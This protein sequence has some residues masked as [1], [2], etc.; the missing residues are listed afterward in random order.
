[1]EEFIP[2]YPSPDD[3]DIQ[4]IITAKKE[5]NEFDAGLCSNR[6][7]SS[8]GS[9]S[10][11]RPHQKLFERLCTITD[12]I[13]NIHETGTGKTC[14]FIGLTEHYKDTGAYEKVLI[15]EKNEDLIKEIKDQ[16]LHKCT[17]EGEYSIEKQEGDSDVKEK[18]RLR[19][20]LDDWYTFVT[21]QRFSTEIADMS[22]AL[23]AAKYS[24]MIIIFD[25]GHNIYSS[26]DDKTG[27]E[28]G[29]FD[30]VKYSNFWKFCHSVK[31]CKICVVTA[32]PMLNKHTEGLR[33]VNLLLPANRQ[34]PIK[35]R[36]PRYELAEL[37]PYLR[38][39]ISFFGAA[40]SEV[41][42]EYQGQVI[43]FSGIPMNMYLSKMGD[44]QTETYK[45]IIKTSIFSAE[46]TYSSFVL[47]IINGKETSQDDYIK[48][49]NGK[50]SW[51]NNPTFLEWEH[52]GEY[53]SF[54]EWIAEKDTNGIPTRDFT[55][56]RRLSG[57]MA[58]I[59]SIETTEPGCSFIYH[60]LVSK[61]GI[62]LLYMILTLFGFE[63]FEK[64]NPSTIF[65]GPKIRLNYPKKLRVAYISGDTDSN[66]AEVIKNLF[67][68]PENANGEYLKIIIG[69]RKVRDGVNLFNC[70]RMHLLYPLWNYSSM[71][72]AINRVLRADGHDSLIAKRKE[73][74]LALGYDQPIKVKVKI[75][76]HC[77]D[78]NLD[79][80]IRNL[81]TNNSDYHFMDIAVTKQI[82]IVDIMNI[83]K[84]CA[85]DCI[86]NRAS[87]K[88]SLSD[89]F[90]FDKLV[91]I[92]SWTEISNPGY[93]PY[94]TDPTDYST[95][96]ILYTSPDLVDRT[97]IKLLLKNGSVG[98]SEIKSI[99]ST[100]NLSEIYTA[101]ETF[102]ANH[103]FII[104]ELGEKMVLESS[105]SG[106]NLQRFSDK[107]NRDYI[108]DIAIYD[109]PQ[110]ILTERNIGSYFLKHRYELT[111]KVVFE[112][113]HMQTIDEKILPEK[114]EYIQNLNP[115]LQVSILEELITLR[116]GRES[117]AFPGI[118]LLLELFKG[119][120]Y[121]F[122][123]ENPPVWV[124]VMDSYVLEDNY[125]VLP[126]HENPKRMKVFALNEDYTGWRF[127]LEEERNKYSAMIK[128]II[129]TNMSKYVKY[130]VYA[131]VL[132]DGKFRLVNNIGAT[133]DDG[134]RRRRKKGKELENILND[135]RIDIAVYE[136]LYPPSAS[137]KDRD[138][139]I[140][141]MKESIK[142]NKPKCFID[143]LNDE[144]IKI[145]FL[146]NNCGN[147]IRD[148]TEV[149]TAK[150]ESTGR[151]YQPYIILRRRN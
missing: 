40:L 42:V 150:L 148:F 132:S 45:A 63:G 147:I 78:Y 60:E 124:H 89:P 94:Q 95:Y 125:G 120:L 56:L 113:I 27:D 25:E 76:R 11:L 143:N 59:L 38:G 99:F 109:F 47:P 64:V 21:Y 97:M 145:L 13:L 31:R 131:H 133:D 75:Y 106:L 116:Y 41:D 55:N 134:D 1:M 149:I 146:W 8:F 81:S 84:S 62:K 15:V 110:L 100:L 2:V 77:I 7:L 130:P 88:L 115:W 135:E 136:Y 114:L 54:Q 44:L 90:N 48:D 33:L 142:E 74:A 28:D 111:K 10:P 26:K 58:E 123:S 101:I 73:E 138:R 83:M 57:K 104:N 72:Q 82:K 122:R 5:F 17:P 24:N 129:E 107:N 9:K 4:R 139:S 92:P 23:I 66:R 39:K 18:R 43:D 102:K 98:Y 128:N 52:R 79:E 80:N 49:I 126:E 121:D 93:I 34:I 53:P 46:K 32:T 96:N 67:N 6:G 85:M 30:K 103:R 36:D 61:A 141:Y 29:A 112:F 119:Y 3:P 86:I 117:S 70:Q 51:I 50:L 19:R 137:C 35:T 144:Q 69:S 22:E 68:S 127:P 118:D 91:Y 140:K 151:V 14:S 20:T 65:I 37:E 12:R 108:S 105:P 71:T 87:G 16:I